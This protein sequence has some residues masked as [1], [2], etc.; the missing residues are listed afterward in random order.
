M[1]ELKQNTQNKEMS[2]RAYLFAYDVHN[3]NIAR[4][5]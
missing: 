1:G 2:G 5:S 3:N 4:T